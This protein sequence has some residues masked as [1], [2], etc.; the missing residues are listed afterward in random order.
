MKS[1]WIDFNRQFRELSD[2]IDLEDA[3]VVIVEL[4]NG[5]K[6][7]IGRFNQ[8]GGRC[9]CCPGIWNDDIIKRYKIINLE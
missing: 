2:L 1:D 9:D 8:L 7:S 5:D 3:T 6:I 4:N